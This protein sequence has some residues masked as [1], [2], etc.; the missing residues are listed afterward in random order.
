MSGRTGDGG[1]GDGGPEGAG[2][3]PGAAAGAEQR[4][5][6]DLF[7]E[8]FRR[9]AGEYRWM[10]DRGYPSRQLVKL[11]GDRHRLSAQSRSAL[12]R[13]V[14][15]TEE[16]RRTRA[17]LA[18]LAELTGT[19]GG[20]E[21]PP[22]A[23]AGEGPAL[24]VDGHNVLFAV[25]H[26]LR[27]VPVYVATDGVLRDVGGTVRRFNQWET[28]LRAVAATVETLA[29][30]GVS[31]EFLLD[32]PVDYSR[33]HARAIRNCLAEQGATGSC[34]VIPSVDGALQERLRRGSA[35]RGLSTGDAEV[36]RRSSGPLVDLARETLELV[37]AASVPE[38][39]LE[40]SP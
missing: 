38:I 40:E 36:I 14:L 19:P 6:A 32:E 33:E 22:G 18:T 31:A 34:E 16:S 37:F 17:R 4:A 7:G 12:F 23:A 24:L 26:Y 13:G 25:A 39:S 29:R 27:G 2:S 11:V 35:Q 20:S 3:R 30:Y 21:R 10:L 1:P 28:V 5:G 15:S 8:T 9:A